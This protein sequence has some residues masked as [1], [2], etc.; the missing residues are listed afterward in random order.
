MCYSY[1]SHRQAVVHG[2]EPEEKEKEPEQEPGQGEELVLVEVLDYYG[3][4]YSTRGSH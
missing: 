3:I 4:C 1:V 2:P